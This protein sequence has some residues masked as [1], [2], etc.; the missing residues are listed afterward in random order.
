MLGGSGSWIFFLIMSAVLWMEWCVS[1]QMDDEDRER[2]KSGV[3]EWDGGQ[4][5][6]VRQSLLSAPFM[7]LMF[8]DDLPQDMMFA[9][10]IGASS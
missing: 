10:V 7:P 6:A 8:P 5:G 9:Q 4:T 1:E 2:R 3:G